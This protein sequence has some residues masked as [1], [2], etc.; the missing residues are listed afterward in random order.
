MYHFWI[1]FLLSL[2]KNITITIKVMKLI[3]QKTFCSLLTIANE[4]EILYKQNF[5][6]YETI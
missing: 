5:S 2:L 4:P 6:D 1:V 3:I